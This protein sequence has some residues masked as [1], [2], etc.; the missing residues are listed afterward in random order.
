MDIAVTLIIQG[1]A[2]FAV[3]LI[4]MRFGWPHIIGA[5][6]ERQKKIAEGLAAGSKAQKDLDEA[7]IKAAGDHSRGARQGRAD[8]RSGQQARQRNRRGGQANGHR[9]RPA[10][11]DAGA[12]G[13]RARHHARPRRSAQAGG[14]SGGAGR[15]APAGARDRS[16]DARRNCSTS[17]SWRSRMA[18]AATIARPVRQ[19]GLHGGA[20]CQG[21]WQPGRKALQSAAASRSAP[22]RRRCS[23]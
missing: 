20:R 11:R 9:R 6:E 13:N 1:I 12:R 10:P 5:I 4:V 21:A 16:E 22:M 19:S 23:C 15:I 3:V 17:W 18:E 14:E 8:R 2:F 7:K